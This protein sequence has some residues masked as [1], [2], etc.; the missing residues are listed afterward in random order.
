M[1]N[2]YQ[3]LNLDRSMSCEEL[4]REINRQRRKYQMS[5]RMPRIT[6]PSSRRKKSWTHCAKQLTC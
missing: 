2:Y 1:I 4:R 6:K 5:S 3:E